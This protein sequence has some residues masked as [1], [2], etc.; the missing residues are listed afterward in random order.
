M[1]RLDKADPIQVRNIIWKIDYSIFLKTA[2]FQIE[3]TITDNI[4]IPENVDRSAR[5]YEIQKEQETNDSIEV[6]TGN[7]VRLDMSTE[8]YIQVDFSKNA[9][10]VSTNFDLKLILK[11]ELYSVVGQSFMFWWSLWTT[12]KL[13]TLPLLTFE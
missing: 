8:D 5:T 2:Y 12:R 9:S 7:N 10:K 1:N 11:R 4:Q 3:T 13:F 6:D